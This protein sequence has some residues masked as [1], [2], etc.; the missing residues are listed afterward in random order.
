[1]SEKIKSEIHK[2]QLI[3]LGLIIVFAIV[4]KLY[5]VFYWPTATIKVNNQVFK[6]LVANSEKHWQK[7]LG[8]RKD[9]GKYDGMLFVFPNQAQH[10]FVMRD[11]KFPLDIIWFN[12]GTVVDKAQNLPIEPGVTEEELVQYPA[13]DISDRVLEISAGSALKYNLNI[14]DNLEVLK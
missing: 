13:R 3:L 14:G 9:L 5:N 12:K 2:W 1:M 4:L 11:M 6:V 10:I 8:G 7:G